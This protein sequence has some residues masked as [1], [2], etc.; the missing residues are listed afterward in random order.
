VVEA[1]DGLVLEP[2]LAVLA[3]GGKH[4]RVRRSASHLVA[5]VSSTPTATF[6]PSVDQLFTSGAHAVGRG[7]LGVVLTGMGNDGLAGAR[8]IAAE[9]G[10]LLTEAAT[11]SI[12]YGM[13]RVV[14]EAGLGARSVPLD[15]IAAEITR[16]V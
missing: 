11:T 14:F 3:R 10:G 1:H 4:L 15:R 9:G 13:P 5:E 12:I 7:A 6:T 8:L 16:R 2:G